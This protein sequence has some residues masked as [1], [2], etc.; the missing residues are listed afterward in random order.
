MENR[1]YLKI[2]KI[3]LLKLENLA[4]LDQE[5]FFNKKPR[6]NLFKDNL[7]AILLVQGAALHYITKQNGIKDFDVLVLYKENKT[8]KDSKGL[9]KIPYRRPKSYDCGMPEFGTYPED[10][11][12]KYP[13]RRIDVLIR[14]IKRKYLKD[15]TVEEA[16]RYCFSMSQT[17]S[18]KEWRKKGVVGIYPEEILGKI[19]WSGKTD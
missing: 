1:S 5:K 19:I 15:K 6:Y 4:K 12:N 18:M 10:N 11:K 7:Y 13:N 17:K 8:I 2:E 14:E 16:L 9:I 3:H